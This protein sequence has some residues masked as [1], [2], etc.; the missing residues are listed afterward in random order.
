MG[1]NPV[2]I[3][4]LYIEKEMSI[5]NLIAI[6]IFVMI[7]SCELTEEI[8][9]EK[10]KATKEDV[11]ANYVINKQ[12]FLRLAKFFKYSQFKAA[13]YIDG[14]TVSVNYED[15]KT[16]QIISTEFKLNGNQK[17]LFDGE[18]ISFSDLKRDLDSINCTSIIIQDGY[19]ATHGFPYKVYELKYK[20]HVGRMYFYYKFFDRPLQKIESSSY[21][22]Q[23]DSSLQKIDENVIWYFN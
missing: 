21:T 6:S 13:H 1:C 8:N 2:L 15:P 18:Y 12:I 17:Q 10:L 22:F 14:N 4:L 20:N 16:K 3:E 19:D 23:P 9:P 7:A 11:K 5:K